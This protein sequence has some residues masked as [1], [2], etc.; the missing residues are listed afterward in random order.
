VSLGVLYLLV[1]AR[2]PRDQPRSRICSGN[3]SGDGKPPTSSTKELVEQ[4]AMAA[5]TAANDD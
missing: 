3:G 4:T 5:T 1:V 2:L